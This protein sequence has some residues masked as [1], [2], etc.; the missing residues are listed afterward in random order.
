MND[1]VLQRTFFNLTCLRAQKWLTKHRHA[2]AGCDLGAHTVLA[3]RRWL[4]GLWLR[5]GNRLLY[6]MLL[7]VICYVVVSMLWVLSSSA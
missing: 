3:T 4:G 1:E 6:V 5:S 2:Y 7:Y